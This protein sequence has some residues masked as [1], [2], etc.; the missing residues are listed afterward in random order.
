[1]AG[2][3]L[4]QAQE[5]IPG[6]TARL[7]DCRVEDVVCRP[8]DEAQ[9][10]ELPPERLPSEGMLAAGGRV[11]RPDL[12]LETSWLKLVIVW[13]AASGVANILLAVRHLSR[14]WP[15]RTVPVLVVPYMGGS[16]ARLCA[17]ENVSWFDLS[18]NAALTGPGVHVHIEGKRNRHQRRGRPSSCFAARSVRVVRWLLIHPER[19][20]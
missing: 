7:L 16:G 20:F 13:R 19:R 9:G 14:H 4:K 1:V 10:D 8:W 6:Q 5:M 3:N 18:G 15:T 2:L 17:E 12:V 11:F